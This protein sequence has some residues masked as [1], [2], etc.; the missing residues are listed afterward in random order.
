MKK[1]TGY[2]KGVMEGKV[3]YEC[4][5]VVVK[6]NGFT[7]KKVEYLSEEDFKKLPKVGAEC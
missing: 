6:N 5:F 1:F 7:T 4:W 2:Q 3:T